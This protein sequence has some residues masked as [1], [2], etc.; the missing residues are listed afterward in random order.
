MNHPAASFFAGCLEAFAEAR[1]RR[2]GPSQAYRLAGRGVTL[3]FAGDALPALLLPALALE[4]AGAPLPGL[5][6]ALW[7]FAD[8]G[9]AAPTPPWRWDA[10]T[11]GTGG[12]IMMPGFDDPRFR[13]VLGADYRLLW[14]LD[15]E[16]QQAIVWYRGARLLPAWE[17]LHPLRLLLHTWLRDRGLALLHA[18]SVGAAAGG[19]LI[20]GSGGA[21]KSTTV[22]A[23]LAGGLTSA[24][25]DYVALE[26]EP[27]PRIHAL[28]GTMRLFADHAARFPGL[29]P[30]SDHEDSVEGRAKLAAYVGRHR[31]AALV[32]SLALR[33]VVAPRVRPGADTILEPLT[34]EEAL[35]ALAP[36]TLQQ[37]SPDDGVLAAM[38]AL[39]RRLPCRRLVLGR[40]LDAVP[41]LLAG[42]IAEAGS[43]MHA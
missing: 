12:R 40:N 22:L 18:G 14:M 25:D 37:L 3:D 28:Y 31:S 27:A 2:P 6:V 7:D 36:S 15:R 29:L 19:A 42:L 43:A 4:P 13:A 10:Y 24:G 34:A 5:S 16:T 17:H 8:G 9:V 33:A 32:A 39:C 35:A 41:G 1:R 23:A 11:G 26:S 30:A 20:A 21:G 38:A